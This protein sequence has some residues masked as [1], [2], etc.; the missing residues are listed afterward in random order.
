MKAIKTLIVV[1]GQFE[2]IHC[3]PECPY[4]GVSFLRV[5]HRHI[6]HVVAKIEVT[7][8]DREI[9]FIL[10]KRTLGNFLYEFYHRHDLGSKSCE[11]LAKEIGEHLNGHVGPVYMISVSED[12]EN[13]SEVFFG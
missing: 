8:D 9:E 13:S 1:K 5:P 6:F 2:G 4:E 11:M 3:W 7:H 10:A 12:E